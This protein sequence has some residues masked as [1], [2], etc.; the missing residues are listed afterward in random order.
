MFLILIQYHMDN[1]NLPPLF[2]CNLPLQQ[3]EICF[4]LAAAFHLFMFS[5]LAYMYDGSKLLTNTHMENNF[6]N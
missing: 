6:I 5:I 1:F 4:P 3:P 2:V